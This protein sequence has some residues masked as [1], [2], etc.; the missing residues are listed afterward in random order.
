MSSFQLEDDDGTEV[1]ISNAKEVKFIGSGVTT[2]WTDTDNGTD[3]DPYDMT[4]TVDAAQTGITSVYNA[5]LKVGRDSGNLIDFATTDNKLIFRVECVNEVELVQN[6]L[7][8]VTSDGVAL[9]TGSL[10]WSDAFLASGSVI[11]FNN[12]DVTLTHSAC[13]LTMAGGTLAAPTI[14]ATDIK[15]G[16]DDETKVDFA[17]AN[18]INLHANNIKA[19]SV[20]NTSSKGELRFY[21]GANYVGFAAPALSA[22]QVWALPTADGSCGQFLKTDGSGALSWAAASAPT[23]AS[24]GEMKCEATGTLFVPPDLVKY[25]PGVAKAWVQVPSNGSLGSPSAANSYNV[26]SVTAN[27]TGDRTIAFTACMDNTTY[28][29]VSS[30]ADDS[31]LSM[32]VGDYAQGSFNFKIYK[33]C[34]LI[35][36]LGA[37][38]AFGVLD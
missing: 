3:G 15:I 20:H 9:G 35:D 13:T 32:R 17:D 28:S 16:E 23:E 36:K 12:G 22:N 4:I 7:S 1:A 19:L 29:V 8:P 24:C 26:A 11:N 25:S 30:A 10:M 37:V 33:G 21:E 14:L 6:A 18:I 34:T 27:S 2:N 38:A 5:S 31:N